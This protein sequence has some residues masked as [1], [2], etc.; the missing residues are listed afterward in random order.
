MATRFQ[1]PILRLIYDCFQDPLCITKVLRARMAER[2]VPGAK[3]IVLEIGC[4]TRPYQKLLQAEAT[5]YIGIDYPPTAG[6]QARYDIG[7]HAA[8][9]PIK[10]ESVDCVLCFEVLNY[11]ADPLAAFEEIHRVLKPGGRFFLSAPL[12]RGISSEAA[13]YFRF[14]PQGLFLLAGRAGLIIDDNYMCGGLWAM[15][16]QRVSSAIALSAAGKN[17]RKWTYAW[18]CGLVQCAG[19]LLNRLRPYSSECLHTLASGIKP[20][21][22]ALRP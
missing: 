6:P 18:Q 3:G 21:R 22:P 17:A 10:D 16:G 8:A 15:I 14:T 4:G 1:I 11:L 2:Y 19:L 9:L 13:D 20:D 7:G 5:R 12:I